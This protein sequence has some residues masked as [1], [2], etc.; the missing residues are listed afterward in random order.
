MIPVHTPL[1]AAE[2]RRR[3][4]IQGLRAVAVLLVVA[5]HAGLA[6]SGGFTGVD[7][8]FVISGFVITGMLVR[9]HSS[10]GRVSFAN[11]YSRRARRI[12]PGLALTVT[13][14]CVLAFMAVSPLKAK[15]STAR[16]G[17][18]AMFSLANVYLLRHKT[19]YF[20]VDQQA[21]PLLHTW[22]LSVEE[23]FYLVFPTL[24]A[25]TWWCSRRIR[26]NASRLVTATTVVGFTTVASFAYCLVRTSPGPAADGS[27][28]TFAFY[29]AP[30]RVWEFGAGALVAL[31]LPL[32]R[33]IPAR[34]AMVLGGLGLVVVG[35]GAFEISSTTR[36]PGT[37]ALLPVVGTCL[38]LASG[39]VCSSGISAVLSHRSLQWIGDLSYSW[40]LW[41]WPFIVFA[42]ALWPDSG[43]GLGVVAAVASLVPAWLAYRFVENPIRRDA[44]LGG[45][46]ALVLAGVCV[47]VPVIACAAL[48]KIDIV[49]RSPEVIGFIAAAEHKHADGIRHCASGLPIDREPATC[50]WHVANNRGT[51][52][53]V[54]DSEAG[55][56][57]EPAARAAN[58][59]GYNFLL[60]TRHGCGFAEVLVLQTEAGPGCIDYVRRSVAYLLRTRPALVLMA[61][62]VP[63]IL[64]PPDVVFQNP[65]SGARSSS[66]T[67]KAQ[68]W[69][70][71]VRKA[72]LPLA[73]AG[74]PTVVIH[75]IPQF[76]SW[77]P[78]CAAIRVY[79]DVGS[80]GAWKPR[81]LSDS[82]RRRSRLAEDAAVRDLPK[83]ATVDF[84]DQICSPRVCRI[85][86]NGLW[87]YRDGTHLSWAGALT[88]V[89]DFSKLIEAHG[90]P[91][92]S[93]TPS[94][95]GADPLG[96]KG[97]P[98]YAR[99]ASS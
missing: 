51:I 73:R 99:R 49:G 19:G 24:L 95:P 63:Y 54:G 77:S 62:S 36:F 47:A 26:R 29:M 10:N 80:C 72:V 16:T 25:V 27:V 74:I 33:K 40:Y 82:G 8:F 56:F 9:E 83:A 76:V 71:G 50:T 94:G 86:R 42:A 44:R 75:T 30:T 70:E 66:P 6:V 46:R 81:A 37:A 17:L 32:V 20:G 41:H 68:I 89:D 85:E 91:R 34:V 38:L 93:G 14:T 15:A 57:G 43:T 1:A 60:G 59:L 11:F 28:G 3:G 90:T 92:L 64:N 65:D 23:Q 97:L 96:A 45:P 13:V 22:S 31:S 5:V 78:D 61:S 35:A 2:A 98:S 67:A 39:A 4:D 12:L 69:S 7:V 53:L 84:A 87:L 21:N 79:L 52:V 48:A 58:R 88:L 55:M 18:S